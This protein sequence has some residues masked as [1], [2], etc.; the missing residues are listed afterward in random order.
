M[1]EPFLSSGRY[2]GSLEDRVML[3]ARAI[4]GAG[5]DA[6]SVQRRNGS[7]KRFDEWERI[8]GKGFEEF[9]NRA[10]RDWSPVLSDALREAI[11]VAEARLQRLKEA[12]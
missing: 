12:S 5:F 2:G 8:Y 1:C 11:G 7:V 10:P 9:C 6:F 4:A 3:C